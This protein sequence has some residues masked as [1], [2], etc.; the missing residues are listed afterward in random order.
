MTAQN[1]TNIRLYAVETTSIKITMYINIV[2][3]WVAVLQHHA[4]GAVH[5]L[6]NAQ[7]GRGSSQV[8]CSVTGEG[9]RG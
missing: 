7:G 2:R 8:L 4:I 1:C 3:D 5:K 9:G 6:R